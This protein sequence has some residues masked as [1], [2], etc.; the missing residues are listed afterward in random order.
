MTLLTSRE[1]CLV[2]IAR[3]EPLNRRAKIGQRLVCIS[4]D[5]NLFPRLRGST[6][7]RRTLD[8]GPLTLSGCINYR[9]ATG[10][11]ELTQWMRSDFSKEQAAYIVRS[12]CDSALLI[13]WKRGGHLDEIPVPRDSVVQSAGNANLAYTAFFSA[14][15]QEEEPTL[16]QC[17]FS[18]LASYPWTEDSDG[19]PK[20]QRFWAF[21]SGT[22]TGTGSDGQHGHRLR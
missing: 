10:P 11:S 20:E 3:G 8:S 17:R 9:T 18:Y 21:Q 12:C 5:M 4:A 6:W 13:V 16:N 1:A 15:S 14:L 2:L 19:L 7:V 22:G